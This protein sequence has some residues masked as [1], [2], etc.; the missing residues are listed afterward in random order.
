M[1]LPIQITFRNMDSS[2][3]VEARVREEVEKLSEFYDSIMGCRVMVEIPHQHRQ[4]GK[5]FHIRID[6]TVPGGEIVVKHEPSL[7]V[8]IQRTGTEKRMKEQE[9]AAPHKDIYVA[10]RDVFKAARRRL[11]DYARKQNGAVKPHE[12]APRAHVS[13]LF[14]E[15][16]YGYLETLDGSEI[17]FHKNSVLNDGFEKLAIGT[18]VSFVEEE[19]DQ[20]LAVSAVRIVGRKRRAGRA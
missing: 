5:R 20:G 11:Q 4:Q 9:I 2:P 7:H 17:Y 15:E 14:P 16:G 8:S 13:R 10:I 3:A 12:P 1:Q 18:E 6:L 19:G